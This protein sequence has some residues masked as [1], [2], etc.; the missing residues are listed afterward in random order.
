MRLRYDSKA[1][2][3]LELSNFLIKQTD[4][5]IRLDKSTVLE[6]G[7]GKGEMLV[8]LAY[9]NPNFKFIGLEKYETVAA[10]CLKRAK[11]LDLKNFFIL[12]EDAKNIGE[13]FE[14]KCSTIW[15]TFSDP[16]PKKKHL[17]RRL[18]HKFFLDK[19]SEI[20]D[21]NGILKFKS[22]NDKL[23]DFSLNSLN[24]ANWKIIDNGTD[25]HSSKHSVNNIMTGYEQKWSLLG[26]NINYIF[27]MKPA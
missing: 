25:L 15:L 18:T 6:I 20:L 10:K 1:K 19:Y 5:K 13:I 2:E 17:K 21:N 9:K 8:E 22:D 24:E 7:M 12:I 3:K 27:A 4:S 11:E 14:G 16:W 26:K 23:Y